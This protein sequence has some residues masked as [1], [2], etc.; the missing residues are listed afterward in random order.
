MSLFKF[1]NDAT[2]LWVCFH[3]DT[4]QPK[5]I[6]ICHTPH[7][8]EY[9]IVDLF[10]TVGEQYLGLSRLDFFQF[11]RDHVSFEP[12]SMVY[13]VITNL[14]RA[15]SVKSAQQN[16]AHRHRNVQSHA[17]QKSGT[18]ETNVGCSDAQRFTGTFFQGKNIIR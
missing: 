10:R 3:A 12:N 16:A 18:F 11:R 13:H 9:G 1:S 14:I 17:R 4:F 7:G 8:S 2:I 6:G 5:L 15:L